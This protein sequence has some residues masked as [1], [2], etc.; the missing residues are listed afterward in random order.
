[1][2]PTPVSLP[3]HDL[4]EALAIPYVLD[5][6]TRPGP[7]GQ[8]VCRLEYVELEGCVAEARDALDALNLL[9]RMREQWLRNALDSGRPVP[10]PRDALRS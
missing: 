4:S 10:R 7:S 3:V 5:V 1:M 2:G 6:S 9:E 8:W